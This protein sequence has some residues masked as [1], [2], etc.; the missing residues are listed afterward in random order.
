MRS[1]VYEVSAALSDLKFLLCLTESGKSSFMQDAEREWNANAG[2]I[3]ISL[4]A[5]NFFRNHRAFGVELE[6]KIKTN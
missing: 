4:V 2:K 3:E 5:K 6:L 1:E